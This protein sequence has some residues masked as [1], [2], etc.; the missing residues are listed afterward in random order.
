MLYQVVNP[1]RQ[2]AKFEEIQK[3]FSLDG[4]PFDFEYG[5]GTAYPIKIHKNDLWDMEWKIKNWKMSINVDG[6]SRNNEAQPDCPCKDGDGKPNGKI[7]RLD[8]VLSWSNISKSFDYYN[9]SSW[10]KLDYDEAR[11]GRTYIPNQFYNDE[12]DPMPAGYAGIIDSIKREN[13]PC[14]V[15]FPNYDDS[16]AF[17]LPADAFGWVPK[18]LLNFWSL[19]QYYLPLKE[20]NA[21]FFNNHSSEGVIEL[22]AGINNYNSQQFY[23]FIRT[24]LNP[25]IFVDPEDPDQNNP[26]YYY[27]SLHFDFGINLGTTNGKLTYC[28]DT[29]NAVVGLG[30]N[31]T[32]DLKYSKIANQRYSDENGKNFT[33]YYTT[34]PAF[35]IIIKCK[36]N[37]YT[38]PMYWVIATQGYQAVNTFQCEGDEEPSYYDAPGLHPPTVKDITLTADSFWFKE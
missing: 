37:E 26:E 31:A 20:Q 32:S 21:K 1:P 7:S 35:N 30:Y 18:G 22:N 9:R 36:K 25:Y 23:R 38:I 3:L 34:Q 16:F 19:S 29:S 33:T 11:F 10:F 6:G 28:G 8:F 5:Q 27:V 24:Q 4:K 14:S 15:S 17:R 13:L 12:G 2:P